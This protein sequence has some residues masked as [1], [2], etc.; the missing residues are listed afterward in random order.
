MKETYR[1]TIIRLY[2]NKEQK[3]RLAQMFGACRWFYNHTLALRSRHYRMFG[4]KEGFK[5]L[6][7]YRLNKHYTKSLFNRYPWLRRANRLPLTQKLIDQEHA[8]K[9]RY[10]KQGFPQFKSKHKKQTFAI[11][12]VFHCRNRIKNNS[13]K[14]AKD[15]SVRVGGQYRIPEGEI[16]TITIKKYSFDRYEVVVRTKLCLEQLQYVRRDPVGID[17][18][19][20]D[21]LLATS[22]GVKIKPVKAGQSA[23][24]K[25]RYW[26]KVLSRR[27]KG[28]GRWVKAKEHLAKAHYKLSQHRKHV[29]FVAARELLFNARTKQAAPTLPEYIGIEKLKVSNLTRKGGAYKRGSNRTM[30][31][32]GLRYFKQILKYKCEELGVPLIEVNPAYTSK[33]CSS[34]RY[35]NKDISLSVRS[36]QCPSCHAEHDRDINAANNVLL[37]AGIALRGDDVRPEGFSKLKAVVCEA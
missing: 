5:S 8:M 9:S 20:G 31:D 16:T 13:I 7:R 30:L 32:R 21:N 6:N 14:L 24:A 15:L 10:K 23:A 34:C 36:W 4:K 33:D 37:R 3:E 29:L 17:L 19:V 28:S 12:G 1:A 25:I 18:N 27:V 22:D 35:R 11:P 2:P 26:N